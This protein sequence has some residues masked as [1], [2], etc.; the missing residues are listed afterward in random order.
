MNIAQVED[1]GIIPGCKR[2]GDG[3][4]RVDVPA[5]SSAR[6]Q[7]PHSSLFLLVKLVVP[8]GAALKRVPL[9][10][11][12]VL[13]VAALAAF[14]ASL[15]RAAAPLVVLVLALAGALGPTGERV[16]AAVLPVC[17]TAQC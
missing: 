6:D 2:V 15:A 5:R 11:A 13:L 12:A 17:C 8:P 7:Y 10:R 3:Q 9:L 1:F 4:G 16:L 14:L